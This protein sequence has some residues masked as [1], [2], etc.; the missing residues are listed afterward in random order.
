MVATEETPIWF[1]PSARAK[2]IL[3]PGGGRRLLDP[4]YDLKVLETQRDWVKVAVVS[5]TWPPQSVG[6]SGW[7]QKKDL[8]RSQTADEKDC[9]F[10]DL[11]KWTSVP[12]E[13]LESMKKAGLRI[14][15]EDARCA[16]IARGD[17]MAGGMRYF[18]TCYP[19]D[20]GKPYHHWLS[21]TKE[22]ERFT[23]PPPID[24]GAAMTLCRNE[25]EKSLRHKAILEGAPPGEV[26][27]GAF[28][29]FM[30]STVHYITMDY[31]LAENGDPQKAYCLVPPG[32]GGEITLA[33]P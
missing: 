2:P 7:V 5:P 18:F 16:R 3:D 30:S 9:F 6:W 25:L 10:V 1:E 12:G 32:G 13:R 33:E 15:A 17:F 14:L 19:I 26:K 20:G 28:S 4:R 22:N 11:S 31:F 29:A 23:P 21:P 8:Q 24:E 27:M